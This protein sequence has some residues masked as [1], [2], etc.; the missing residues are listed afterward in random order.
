MVTDRKSIPEVL[1]DTRGV[2]ALET[3]LLLPMLIMMLIFMIDIGLQL[4]TQV[5]LDSL[6]QTAAR[7][8]QINATS[9]TAADQVRT[10]IC[11]GL[12]SLM[13]H[14]PCSSIQIYATSAI[15]FGALQ[16]A[17]VSNKTLSP[18]TYNAGSQKSVVLLQVA[19]YDPAVA[20]LSGFLSP[21]LLSSTS[22]VNEP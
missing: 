20:L 19:F 3:A 14:Q 4:M 12:G 5:A 21:T 6:T 2:T 9:R 13:L 18:S 11:Q 10:A 15:T 16:P 17:Q 1:S 22:F 7:Q 8:I